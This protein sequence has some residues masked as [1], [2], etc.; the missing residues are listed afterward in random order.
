MENIHFG[1]VD[2]DLPDWRKSKIKEDENDNDEDV[3]IEADVKA[4]LGF[5]PDDIKE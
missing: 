5:D 2:K 3:D 4:I 1:K